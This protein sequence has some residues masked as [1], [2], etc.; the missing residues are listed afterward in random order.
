MTG[1]QPASLDGI[2][3]TLTIL[4][5][6]VMLVVTGAMG[7]IFV[8]P[9]AAINPFPPPTETGMAVIP[10]TVTDVLPTPTFTDT[11][12]PP[13]PTTA[14]SQTPTLVVIPATPASE[15]TPTPSPTQPDT[16][17]AFTISGEPQA[18]DSTTYHPE[19]G[20]AFQGIAGQVLDLRG[21]P[22]LGVRVEVRGWLN[23]RSVVLYGMTGLA[24]AY[25]IGGYELKLGDEPFASRGEIWVRLLDQQSI[26]LSDKI[27]FDTYADCARNL[28]ILQF[29]QVR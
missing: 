29:Q 15:P 24:Q 22:V 20:C 25:G 27:Y 3:N 13:T 4:T 6:A 23:G 2:W 14:A 18:I 16:S 19:L 8:Q 11:P 28:T 12:V 7:W 17:Y 10:A 1:K 26:P 9:R 5:L 21:T